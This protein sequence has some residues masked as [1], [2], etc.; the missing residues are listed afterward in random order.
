M[1]AVAVAAVLAAATAV[2]ALSLAV[3]ATASTSAPQVSDPG[4][5]RHSGRGLGVFLRPA[6]LGDEM[7]ASGDFSFHRPAVQQLAHLRVQDA[8]SGVEGPQRVV[9][10]SQITGGVRYPNG[11]NTLS[12]GLPAAMGSGQPRERSMRRTRSDRSVSVLPT[13]GAACSADACNGY[14]TA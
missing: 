8:T 6:C 1:R 7:F 14:T 3:P 11:P 10:T 2:P 12:G 4:H 5:L 13:T 9:H